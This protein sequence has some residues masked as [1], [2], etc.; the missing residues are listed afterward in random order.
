MISVFWFL[1]DT[2]N[3]G[4]KDF[5]YLDNESQFCRGKPLPTMFP[6]QDPILT[7]AE[8]WLCLR[9]FRPLCTS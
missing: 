5:F 8:Q 2:G 1:D 7:M 3:G 9:I 4:V 6:V